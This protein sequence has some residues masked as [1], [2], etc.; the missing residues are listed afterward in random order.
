MKSIKTL[1]HDFAF[2]AHF[3]TNSVSHLIQFTSHKVQIAA[4]KHPAI[5]FVLLV[6]GSQSAFLIG[7]PTEKSTNEI[8]GRRST[9]QLQRIKHFK[10]KKIMQ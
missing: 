7:W 6:P 2:L 8:L 4:T 1:T 3:R 10:G 5:E 9:A